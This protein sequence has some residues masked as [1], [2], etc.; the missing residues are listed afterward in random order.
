MKFN[1][2]ITYYF[3]IVWVVGLTRFP[4]TP[5]SCRTES[6]SIRVPKVDFAPVEPIVVYVMNISG[7]VVETLPH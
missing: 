6:H 3:I 5:S 7:R 1:I 2:T 4:K